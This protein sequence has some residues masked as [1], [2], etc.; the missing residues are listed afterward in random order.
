M[1]VWCTWMYS[2]RLHAEE[3]HHPEAGAEKT[4]LA[5]HEWTYMYHKGT[6]ERQTA[7]GPGYKT[8]FDT[9]REKSVT[10]SRGLDIYTIRVR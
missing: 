8:F 3:T 1:R 9:Q 5:A 2:T 6:L 4:L 7:L 10:D